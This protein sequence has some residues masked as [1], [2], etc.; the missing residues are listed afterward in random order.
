MRVNPKSFMM[1]AGYGALSTSIGGITAM[2]EAIF[3]KE[4]KAELKGGANTA[5]KYANLPLEK[6]S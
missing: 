6:G 2:Q 4:L 1:G 5:F 3:M